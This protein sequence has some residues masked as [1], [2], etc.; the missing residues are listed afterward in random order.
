[1]KYCIYFKNK[2]RHPDGFWLTVKALPLVKA[3]TVQKGL[4]TKY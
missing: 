1:M 4:F 2:I 3:L